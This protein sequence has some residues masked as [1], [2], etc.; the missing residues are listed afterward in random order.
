MRN[1]FGH[2]SFDEMY[3]LLPSIFAET[4][5]ESRSDRY[6]YIPTIQIVAGM[7]REGFCLFRHASTESQRLPP[8]VHKSI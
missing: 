5:H 1:Q 4:P 2:L 6:A 3:P 8:R 7:M